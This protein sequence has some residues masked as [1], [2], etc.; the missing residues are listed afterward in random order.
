[1]CEAPFTGFSDPDA[2]V[3]VEAMPRRNAVER[4]ATHSASHGASLRIVPRKPIAPVAGISAASP[5]SSRTR[6][7]G[8]RPAESPDR[9]P[10][11]P[12]RRPRGSRAV[13]PSQRTG[14]RARQGKRPPRSGAPRRDAVVR[15]RDSSRCATLPQSCPCGR[16][17][18]LRASQPAHPLSRT[19]RWSSN[20]V[21][22]L[23]LAAF[24]GTAALPAY[25]TTGEGSAIGAARTAQTLAGGDTAAQ[26]VSRDTLGISEAPQ[27][28][29]STTNSTVSPSVQALAVQLMGAVASGRL[30]GSTPNHLPEIANL[31]EGKTVP[32]CGVDYRVL[33][34]ISIALDHFAQVGVSDINRRCTGQIEGAGTESAHYT[35]GGGHALDF[36]LLNGSPLTGGDAKSIQ[37]IKI[38]DPLVPAGTGLGQIECRPSLR[39]DSFQPFSDSCNHLHIDFLKAQGATLRYG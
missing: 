25:A 3:C 19:R 10:G 30:V 17:Q 38:L 16:P 28:L 11:D 22:V 29:T 24:F 14:R 23:A 2:F 8:C 18:R 39:L 7:G 5:R 21:V 9:R 32:G 34:T 27:A 31:A 26:L 35:D 13:Q 15:R 6:E 12:R 4:D 1:M 37:L 33:Q 36:Y 20:T